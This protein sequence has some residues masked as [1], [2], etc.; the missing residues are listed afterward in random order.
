[1]QGNVRQGKERGL[2]AQ[3]QHAP[4]VAGV[5]G[6]PAGWIA[7]FRDLS[8]REAP[9]V[10]V[11]ARFADV[12]DAPENPA[13]IAVDM[14]IGLP[15]VTDK[16]GRGPEQ[17][18]RTVL[19]ARRS[20]V[21]AIPARAAV[22]AVAPQPVGMA[23]L[24]EGHRQALEIARRHSRTA[25]G[26]PFQTFN[27][28]PKIREIDELLRARAEICSRVHESHPEAAFWAMNGRQPLTSAKKTK[29]RVNPIGMAERRNLLGA[30]GV[31][32]DVLDMPTPRGAAADDVM[33]A[34]AMSV[35]AERIL[36][37]EALSFPDPPERDAFGLPV[38]IRA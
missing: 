13:V 19:G 1:M 29:G 35:V 26:F 5:D 36:R 17:L 7:A 15:E 34:L 30:A 37:G 11:A 28:L 27:I 38:A 23:L 18:L 4:W 6:C 32:F 16:G 20:S 22:F 33:D 31:P 10:R 3:R 8:G 21:F 24:L 14:P 25:S 12:A 9:R 2:Q